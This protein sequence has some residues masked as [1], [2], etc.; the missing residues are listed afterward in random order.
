MRSSE[1]ASP[2]Q[3]PAP[4][5]RWPS[6]PVRAPPPPEAAARTRTPSPWPPPP[7]SN[8]PWT[9]AIDAF[10]KANPGVDVKATYSALD[11]YQTTTRTQLSSGTAPDIVFVWPGDGNPMAMKTVAGANFLKD[12]SGQPFASKLPDAV[13]K[14]TQI[15]GK[16]YIAPITFSGIGAVYN[17]DALTEARPDRADHLDRADQVLLRRQG[18]GQGRLRPRRRHPVEHPADQLRPHPHP[19][20]RAGPG[21]PAGDG[22]RQGHLRRLEVGG[23]MDK[24]KEMQTSGCFQ[25]SPLGTNYETTLSM[26]GK[27]DALGVVQVNSAVPGIKKTAPNANLT[28]LPL[29]ATD[30]ADR[31]PDG[32]RH[33]F[34]LRHQ[35][36]DQEP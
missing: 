3:Q 31:H 36:Q 34:L 24:Y 27:G 22:R 33:R 20:L 8:R 19:G 2:P 32:R 25:D 12:L 21:L 5:S 1:P 16:T 14:V 9:A 13:K 11:Q 15:D 30:D 26:V 10:K 7:T 4:P 6:R 29:P 18:Q 23:L 35:R 17:E 28:L